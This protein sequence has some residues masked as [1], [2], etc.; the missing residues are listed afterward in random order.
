MSQNNKNNKNNKIITNRHVITVIGPSNSGKTLFSYR[1]LRQR[2]PD[3]IPLTLNVNFLESDCRNWLIADYTGNV[4]ILDAFFQL[5]PNTKLVVVVISYDQMDSLIHFQKYNYDHL[6]CVVIYNSRKGKEI[7]PA[8]SVI[9]SK[10][11][12]PH[13]KVDCLTGDGLLTTR[14]YIMSVLI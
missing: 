10:L 14:E 7:S 11:D 8:L 13:F 6:P 4:R 5:M 9:L 2:P 1:L 3:P 12:I